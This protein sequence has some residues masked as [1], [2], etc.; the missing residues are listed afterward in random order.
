[1]AQIGP[2]DVALVPIW[3]WGPSIGPG[4]M[5]PAGAAASL[6]LLRPKV[7]IPIHWGTYHPLFP[8]T[9]RR[10][11]WLYKPAETFRA[12]AATSAPDVEVRILRP[13]ERTAV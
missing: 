10:P 5:D 9:A 6:R 3:G 11:A 8:G 4:H 13:G 12:E 7:A 1:M 2:V